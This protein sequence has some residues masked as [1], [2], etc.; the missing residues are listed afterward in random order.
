[1]CSA[2][3]NIT[4]NEFRWNHGHT[5]FAVAFPPAIRKVL[6]VDK[7]QLSLH[8]KGFYNQKPGDAKARMSPDF[9][10]V[11]R[12]NLVSFSTDCGYWTHHLSMLQQVLVASKQLSTLSVMAG[13][14]YYPRHPSTI[15]QFTV[16]DGLLP[17][18]KSLTIAGAWKYTKEDIPQI[19]DFSKL[20]SLHIRDRCVHGFLMSVP[21][22]LVAGIRTL[23][24]D[25]VI[26][27]I[28]VPRHVAPAPLAVMKDFLGNINGLV[29]VH[30]VSPLPKNLIPMLAGHASTLKYLKLVDTN[31]RRPTINYD[32]LLELQAALPN[33][34]ELQLDLYFLP[35]GDS[36]EAGPGQHVDNK[37]GWYIRVNKSF[38][39]SLIHR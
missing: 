37:Y 17:P 20:E 32:D 15:T 13:G 25:D 34:C 19:W 7:P 21:G 8:L 33:L 22:N 27:A 39:L 12:S 3:S 38:P 31:T 10:A 16:Q 6:E 35:K 11:P 1:M 36:D 2:R 14:K 30:F 23:R 28:S 26:G 4:D 5:D 9:S 29:D 18:I 24:I